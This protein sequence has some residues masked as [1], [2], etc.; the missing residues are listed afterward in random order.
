MSGSLSILPEAVEAV[1]AIAS[2]AF[3]ALGGVV[4]GDFV[5]SGF[6]VPEFVH[7]GGRMGMQVH[8]MPGGKRVIDLLGDDPSDIS[9]TGTFLDFFPQLKAQELDL[10]RAAGQALPLQWGSYFYT[11]IISEFSSDVLY[12]RV[13]YS[14]SCVVLRNE[15]T[16]LL[17][18]DPSLSDSVQGDMSNA[19]GVI[20]DGSFD[21]GA[22]SGVE[23]GGFDG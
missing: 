8:K 18:S 12:G 11:V 2:L 19:S 16:A 9:W 7:V 14:I 22:S 4:L 23:V 17:G 3:G 6:E 21:T 15:A 1:S 13:R 5:F 10:M 20:D